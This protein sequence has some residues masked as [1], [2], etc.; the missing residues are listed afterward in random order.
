[1]TC[2]PVWLRSVN[3]QGLSGKDMR[4]EVGDLKL[5]SVCP[6]RADIDREHQRVRL[7]LVLSLGRVRHLIDLVDRNVDRHAQ[8]ISCVARPRAFQR[9]C[10]AWMSGNGH[11]NKIK[12]GID[13]VGWVVI[14]P[15]GTGEKYLQP[16][17]G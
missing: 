16:R 14:H 5:T 13:L 2:G 6:L 11:R 8:I 9:D 3:G 4:N 17:M 12:S 7:D 1:M 10:L 15:A